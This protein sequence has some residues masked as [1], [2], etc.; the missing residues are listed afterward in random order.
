MPRTVKG[1]PVVRQPWT[2]ADYDSDYGAQESVEALRLRAHLH[3]ALRQAASAYMPGSS[4][5]AF[6][7]RQPWM[8]S[9][10]AT[11]Q[12]HLGFIFAAGA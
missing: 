3:Q 8:E 5:A 4:F 12:N 7:K 6:S 11:L 2:S 9:I 1:L 10:N